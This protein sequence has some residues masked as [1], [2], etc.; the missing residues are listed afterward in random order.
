MQSQIYYVDGDCY[1]RMTRARMIVEHPGTI[2]RHHDFENW[3]QGINSHTTAPLDYMI[4]GL[5]VA[6]DGV[7]RVLDSNHRSLLH[8][9]TLDLA[10][11]L[12][13]PLLGLAGAIF[14]IWWFE[15]FRVPFGSVGL[16]V[17]AVSP[18]LVH[19]F[20]LGRPDHQS[21]L[22]T[23]FTVALGAELALAQ[24][25]TEPALSVAS[26]RWWSVLGGLAWSLS[27]WV[28]LYE[29]TILLVVVLM[30]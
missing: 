24:G 26:E 3:P 12:I 30:L 1:A 23:L 2:V 15:R 17:Y 16:L 8:D 29:P 11:A 18:I 4:V 10:G 20:L 22:M 28:S 7:F 9:Q 6:L 14:L 13:S 5:K 19:G 21:L 27:L 25:S